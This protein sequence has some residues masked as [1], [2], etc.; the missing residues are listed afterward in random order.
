MRTRLL[1]ALG[2]LSLML[3]APDASAATSAT[4]TILTIH[5]TG[6][7]TAGYAIIVM[8]GQPTGSR[9]SC[10]TGLYQY[11]WA[12]DVGTSKGR[13]MLSTATAA[14]LAGKP[15]TVWGGVASPNECVN[16]LSAFGPIEQIA[17]IDLP[18]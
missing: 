17:R 10:H 9:P 11:H 4:N 5:I 16:T 13:A 2:W 6:G 18:S 8:N 15:I 14:M 1:A 12:V 3:G 7:N